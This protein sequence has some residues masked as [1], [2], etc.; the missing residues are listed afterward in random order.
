MDLA[1]HRS[2]IVSLRAQTRA[3]QITITI[4]ASALAGLAGTLVLQ[5]LNSARTIVVPPEVRTSFWVE[6]G[7]VSRSYYLEWGY[8]LAGL[9]LNVSP[10]SAAY[11]HEILLRHIAPAHRDRMHTELA[12]AAARLQERD[13]TTFFAVSGVD[14]R[15]EQGMIAFS[16]SYSSYVQ[17]RKISERLAAFA[18]TFQISRGQ[19][20]LVEFSETDPKSVFQRIDA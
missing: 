6:D 1:H 4:L 17:G 8:Y 12:V 9:L 20:V 2:T 13:L 11:Q 3:L 14:I 19:L 10:S 15:P 16:G 18:L 5:A 7:K